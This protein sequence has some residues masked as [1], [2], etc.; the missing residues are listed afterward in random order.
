MVRGAFNVAT[1]TLK[2]RKVL[3]VEIARA[4]DD[5]SITNT[6]SRSVFKC[7][8]DRDEEDKMIE[9]NRDKDDKKED[10]KEKEEV[11]KFEVEVCRVAGLEMLL[12]VRFQRLAGNKWQYQQ[13]CNKLMASMKL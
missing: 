13:I 3:L 7:K 2:P 4:L 1:T 6:L 11:L 8:V 10:Q 12:G 9:R 5:A